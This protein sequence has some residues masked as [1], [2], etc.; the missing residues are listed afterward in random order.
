MKESFTIN[1]NFL[2][3]INTDSD[4]DG[5][6]TS[7]VRHDNIFQNDSQKKSNNEFTITSITPTKTTINKTL[8]I[9]TM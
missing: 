1:N 2:N 8:E 7:Y 6:T 3:E 4:E 5:R 9:S